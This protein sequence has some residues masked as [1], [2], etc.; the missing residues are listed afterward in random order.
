[1]KTAAKN[2][3]AMSPA[4]NR[5]WVKSAM[6]SI[7]FFGI[8]SIGDRNVYGQRFISEIFPEVDSIADINYGDALNYAG[9][10]ELLYLDFY[11][12][13]H[14]TSHL[15]P[16][17][18][19]AHGGGFSGGSRKWPSIVTM[20]LRLAKEGYAAASMDYR[21]DPH[22][23]FGTSG[24]NRRAMTDAM[25]DMNA[26]IRFFKANSR[27]FG[28]DTARIFIGGESAGAVTAM[29]SGYIDKQEELLKYPKTSPYNIEGNSG[30]PGYSSEVA[31]VVCACGAMVDVTPIDTPQQSPLLWIHGSSDPIVSFSWAEEIT[32]RAKEV[33]LKYK[34]VV[35]KGATHCPWINVFPDWKDY[36]DTLVS[37]I[38]E[39]IYSVISGKQV[40]MQ[41][42]NESF[43]P[44][45]GNGDGR[46]QSVSNHKTII[47]ESPLD[48]N[49]AKKG[50]SP[51]KAVKKMSG[52]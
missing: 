46:G 24:S 36:M 32:E 16:L 9:N 45:A 39:F 43:N 26:A 34:K 48:L 41:G 38:S 49:E 20:C 17:I 4:L 27:K 47:S 29:M 11:E 15:R 30:T 2:Q 33:G 40:A 23:D 18:I 10:N 51:E 6:L 31:G 28:I 21:L 25:H 19:Y 35:L 12:P 13:R 44:G 5:A 42:N 52:L 22:F 8:L 50:L 1:M 37:N 14:D 7:I 3:V